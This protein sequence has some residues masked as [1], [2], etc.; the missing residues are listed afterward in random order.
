MAETVLRGVNCTFEVEG[1]EVGRFQKLDFSKET[2]V[3]EYLAAGEQVAEKLEGEIKL[4][5]SLERGWLNMELLKLA[6]ESESGDGGTELKRGGGKPLKQRRRTVTIKGTNDEGTEFR[7]TLRNAW[8]PKLDL[9][10]SQGSEVAQEKVE[11]A[12]DGYSID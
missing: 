6:T 10:I 1:L 2:E 8:F 12:F 11:I 9:S 3:V 7:L 4:S 5:A